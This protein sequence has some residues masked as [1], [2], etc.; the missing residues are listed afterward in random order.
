MA[1]NTKVVKAGLGYTIGN[2]LIKGLTFLTIPIF[3]RLLST[4]EY[5]KYNTFVAYENILFIIIGFAI[6]SSYKNARYKYKLS[7]EGA[8]KGHDYYSYVSE[9]M[10]LSIISFIIWLVFVNI[11]GTQTSKVFDLD[12]ISMN[13]LIIYSAGAAIISCFNA[14]VSLEYSYKKFLAVSGFN[15]I[16]NI[17]LS[18]I[19][20]V[21]I[22]KK[23]R[24]I[25][26]TLGTVIPIIIASIYII[27][28]FFRR[29]KPSKDKEMLVWGIKFSLPIIPHGLSQV[30]LN[31]FDRIMIS[32][33]VTSAAA[34]V[35]SFAYN[36]YSI[37]AV[38]FASLDN[39]WSPWFYENMH[40]RN[41][42]KIKR[43]SSIYIVSMFIF[44]TIVILVCPEIIK[45]LGSKNY[46]DAMYSAIPIVAGG[47]F[48]FLY[49][50]PVSVEYYHEKTSFI[51]LGTSIAAI[52]NIILNYIFIRLIGYIAAAYT[53]LVTYV[54]YFLF[55][56]YLAK[57]IE[58]RNIFSNKV[59]LLTSLGIIIVMF[60][61]NI[62]IKF[63]IF[64]WILAIL[65]FFVSMWYEEKTIGFLEKKFKKPLS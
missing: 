11:A 60:T 13:L 12:N 42:K 25:G 9:T 16:C 48:S 31:Q 27:G 37:V 64:R 8:K 5:G 6:H 45:I 56:Y 34:G 49:T 46:W 10:I 18:L 29:S 26:Y 47:F 23:D 52:I 28:H 36:I 51:A 40:S 53:T 30:I 41:Y 3:S 21:T 61:A 14:D 24:Y 54:L 19:F 55:H 22:F 2:Y 1:K 62:M 44:C 33:M 32:R 4:T 59:I 58:G 65:I 43:Y 57:K 7:S 38:T 35:Y 15:A 50:I 20:V 63:W 39:V 17:G